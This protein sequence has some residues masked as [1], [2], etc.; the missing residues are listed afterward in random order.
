M[1]ILLGITIQRAD[2]FNSVCYE[3][4]QRKRTNNIWREPTLIKEDSGVITLEELIDWLYYSDELNKK[5]SWISSNC[6]HFSIA[7]FEKVVMDLEGQ[8]QGMLPLLSSSW[9]WP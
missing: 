4:R 6:Q 8:D 7:V 3:Y 2:N 5:Y 1:S 9:P